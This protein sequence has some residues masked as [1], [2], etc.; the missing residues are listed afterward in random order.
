MTNTDEDPDIH[1]NT[2]CNNAGHEEYAHLQRL[3]DDLS[4]S[5]LQKL[6]DA[7]GITFQK[8]TQNIDRD[9]L[10]G[11]VDEADRETFYKKYYEIIDAR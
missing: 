9:V 4:D 5:E 11:V 1:K 7:I 6:V 2:F 3:I 10:E 8:D